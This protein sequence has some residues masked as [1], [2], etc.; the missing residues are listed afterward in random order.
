MS[1][2]I[3]NCRH[4]KP[5][6][7]YRLFCFHWA[8]G[9]SEFYAGWGANMTDSVEVYGVIT[10]GRE[11]RFMEPAFTSAE[12]IAA[13]TAK[14][15]KDNFSDKPFALFGHC[16]G[17]WM[18]FETARVLQGAHE[19][20]PTKLF[21][22]GQFSPHSEKYRSNVESTENMD[23]DQFI[24][25]LRRLG[26]TPSEVLDNRDLMEVFLPTFRADSKCY[27]TYEPDVG[28]SKRLPCPIYAIDGTS[29]NYDHSEWSDL[30]TGETSTK[31]I[32][33]GHFYLTEDEGKNS[34]LQYIGDTL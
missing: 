9:G 2:S 22:S 32:Q 12:K 14:C 29:D 16:M 3:M 10:P 6:A 23:D 19:L 30:T 33:G 8:G 34:L 1:S 7:T 5:N 20:P 13:E 11:S 15:I 25:F 24:E 28:A 17:A 18:A 4:K 27:E 26:G 21:V 31:L